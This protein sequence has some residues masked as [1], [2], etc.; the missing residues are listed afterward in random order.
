MKK[1]EADIFE[2]LNKNVVTN[3]NFFLM[4]ETPS[5]K[6]NNRSISEPARRLNDYDFNLLKEDAYKDVSDDLF[7]LEY[8]IAKTEEEIK[9]LE[10]QIQLAQEIQNESLVFELTS[11]QNVLKEDFEALLA[12]YNN[13]SLSAKITDHVF[14]FFDDKTKTSIKEF[15][16]KVNIFTESILTKLPKPFASIVE[17]K[18]SLIKLENINKSVDE[19]MALNSPYGENFDKYAQLSQFIIKANS[20]Q[21]EISRHIK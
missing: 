10:A 20:I 17:L 7:K 12:M 1:N 13:R 18:K 19:L 11:R 2:G 3:D 16:T 4:D 14:N 21:A 9:D 5:F 8:K 6:S 15:K